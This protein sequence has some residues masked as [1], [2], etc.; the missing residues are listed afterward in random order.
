ME[1]IEL[2]LIYYGFN[3][4]VAYYDLNVTNVYQLNNT[5]LF[6]LSD[7]DFDNYI[8]WCELFIKHHQGWIVMEG[9]SCQ[10]IMGAG[11]LKRVPHLLPSEHFNTD[12][13]YILRRRK[14]IFSS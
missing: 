5:T 12:S 7:R 4:L 11:L 1:V 13:S 2:V 8:S 6:N 3:W 14:H 10:R 9:E